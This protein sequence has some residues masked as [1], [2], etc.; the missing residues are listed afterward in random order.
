MP[1][2]VSIS[3]ILPRFHI[4]ML[5]GGIF[6]SGMLGGS[7]IGSSH[8][9]KFEFYKN[10]ALSI[11]GSDEDKGSPSKW[12]ATE[13]LQA[14]IKEA[15]ASG[16]FAVL[17]TINKDGGVSS[18]LIQPFEVEGD[19]ENNK[20][21]IY[22]NTNLLSRKAAEMA[23][24]SKV[25]LTYVNHRSMSYVTF[26]GD[27]IR[28]PKPLDKQ[29]GHW[30]DWLYVFYPEGPDGNRFSTWKVVPE[31]VQV[32]SITGNLVSTQ[33]NWAPPEVVRDV[34]ESGEWRRVDV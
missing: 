19:L 18:R 15:K 16:E 12:N 4:K 27:A 7:L 30:R 33:E 23:A 26:Q 34:P 14:A 8:P 1:L 20:P 24:N 21:L 32:V 13:V 2:C 28:I 17:S 22:F 10:K 3:R 29:N 11:F 25:S 6:V 5:R 9:D 31:K